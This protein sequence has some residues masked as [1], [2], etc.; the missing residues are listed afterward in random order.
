MAAYF[1]ALKEKLLTSTTSA[2]YQ[3]T[4]TFTGSVTHARSRSSAKIELEHE[5][6]QLELCSRLYTEQS[7]C[8]EWIPACH[9]QDCSQTERFPTVQCWHTKRAQSCLCLSVI[10]FCFILL[11]LALKFPRTCLPLS[12]LPLHSHLLILFTPQLRSSLLLSLSLNITHTSLDLLLLVLLFL[13]LI[14]IHDTVAHLFQWN[15]FLHLETLR[16]FFPSHSRLI[17]DHHDE[18]WLPPEPRCVF[19]RVFSE[20]VDAVGFA[21]I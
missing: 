17:L 16:P 10:C 2:F 4:V 19:T 9:M 11:L 7:I 20:S 21:G 18:K 1:T 3:H 15:A 8:S 13:T 6:R 5:Q 12:V 14:S